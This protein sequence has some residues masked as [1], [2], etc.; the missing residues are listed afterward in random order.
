V[1]ALLKLVKKEWDDWDQYID[2]VLFGYRTA[3]KS[4]KKTLLKM[5]YLR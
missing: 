5:M 1:C 4:T 2:V 3:A